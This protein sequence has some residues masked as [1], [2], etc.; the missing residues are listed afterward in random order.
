MPYR[1]QPAPGKAVDVELEPAFKLYP[2][3]WS[4]HFDWKPEKENYRAS[5]PLQRSLLVP[6]FQPF[7]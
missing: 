2:L 1:L 5:L 4:R 6:A 7:T 3:K